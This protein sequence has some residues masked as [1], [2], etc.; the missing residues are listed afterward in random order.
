MDRESH[1]IKCLKN[2]VLHLRGESR[3]WYLVIVACSY[4]RG[5]CQHVVARGASF[6]SSSEDLLFR[7]VFESLSVSPC[8]GSREPLPVPQ[9]Y[10]EVTSGYVTTIHFNFLS[11]F[12]A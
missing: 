4:S 11:E 1:L 2:A 3:V 5:P 7:P 9:V 6:L 10:L 8:M 12:H